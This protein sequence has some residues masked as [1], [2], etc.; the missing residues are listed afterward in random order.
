MAKFMY[1]TKFYNTL[2]FKTSRPKNILNNFEFGIHLSTK[3]QVCDGSLVDE[4]GM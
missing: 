2:F 1:R 4:L 3:E